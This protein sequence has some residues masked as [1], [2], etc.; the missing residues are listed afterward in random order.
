MIKCRQETVSNMFL[1]IWS[2]VK[3]LENVTYMAVKLDYLF[4]FNVNMQAQKYES[5]RLAEFQL[6][7]F[8]TGIKRKIIFLRIHYA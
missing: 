5:I 2:E 8:Y 4:I 1:M 3:P 6:A 7:L